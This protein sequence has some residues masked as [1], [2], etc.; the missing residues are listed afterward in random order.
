MPSP[1]VLRTPAAPRA[2]TAVS[3]AACLVLAT[4]IVPILAH[5][6]ATSTP[7]DV[8]IPDKKAA[9]AGKDTV[10]PSVNIRAT[11]NGDL[12]EEY[13]QNGKIYMVHITPKHGVPYYL[14]DDDRNGRLDR[15][16][17]DGKL[18]PVY[19]TIYEWD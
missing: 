10:A 3:I 6:Q 16:D 11:D 19:Y 1:T 17:A 5:A 15:T 8:P 13:S 12:V 9:P 4:G 18:S 2:R 7:R 14:Y